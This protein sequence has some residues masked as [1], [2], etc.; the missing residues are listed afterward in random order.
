M[1]LFGPRPFDRVFRPFVRHS[2]NVPTEIQR[3]NNRRPPM[4]LD[5]VVRFAEAQNPSGTMNG[6]SI[7]RDGD[8][9]L[10]GD[11]ERIQCS[12]DSD[13]VHIMLDA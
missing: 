6:W 13:Q 8:E 9:A 4:Q 3:E 11:P 10:A 1:F 5:E 2:H 7:R 12:S